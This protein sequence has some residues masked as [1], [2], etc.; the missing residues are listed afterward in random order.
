MVQLGNKPAIMFA[1]LLAFAAFVSAE[2]THAARMPVE[3]GA[4]G[5]VSLAEA[6]IFVILG[7]LALAAGLIMLGFDFGYPRII[8]GDHTDAE[9]RKVQQLEANQRRRVL[10]LVLGA[11]CMMIACG[12]FALYGK[13]NTTIRPSSSVKVNAVYF[14]AHGIAYALF[15]AIFAEF[16]GLKTKAVLMLMGAFAGIFVIFGAAQYADYGYWRGYAVGVVVILQAGVMVGIL[17]G[18]RPGAVVVFSARAIAPCVFLA[19]SFLLWNVFFMVGSLNE[20]SKNATLNSRSGTYLGFL[21][22]DISMFISA[23]FCLGLLFP[24]I[25]GLY[26]PLRDPMTMGYFSDVQGVPAAEMRR[27]EDAMPLTGGMSFSMQAGVNAG[28]V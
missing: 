5:D 3:Q 11:S 15:G 19:I 8:D 16:M 1:A 27:R 26:P 18:S 10:L 12:A 20:D 23:C 25:P 6:I 9:M 21:G 24:A 7:G 13:I 2:G 22:A 14:A 28:A 17:G 4:T